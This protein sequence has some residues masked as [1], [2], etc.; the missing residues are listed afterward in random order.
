VRRLPCSICGTD[1]RANPGAW[2][3][4][5]RAEGVIHRAEVVCPGACSR[6][7]V[8]MGRRL[9]AHPYDGHLSWFRGR[10]SLLQLGR[11]LQD[12]TWTDAAV[13]QLLAILEPLRTLRSGKGP[14]WT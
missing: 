13:D 10:W 2:L 11:L 1:Q 5:W 12:Y 9:G 14:P 3:R 7:S 4:W 6:Q 8:A